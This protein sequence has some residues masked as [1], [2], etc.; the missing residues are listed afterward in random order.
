MEDMVSKLYIGKPLVGSKCV[1][2]GEYNVTIPLMA[3]S[4][5]SKLSVRLEV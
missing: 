2:N 5:G 3:T 1:Y 4:L